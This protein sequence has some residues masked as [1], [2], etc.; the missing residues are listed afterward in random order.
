MHFQGKGPALSARSIG[1]TRR[2][3]TSLARIH[4]IRSLCPVLIEPQSDSSA[5]WTIRN[6]LGTASAPYINTPAQVNSD[7]FSVT[8]GTLTS[9][10]KVTNGFV[11]HC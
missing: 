5:F 7:T 10:A 3:G 1:A 2:A 9:S 11:T 4:A 8:C 6:L